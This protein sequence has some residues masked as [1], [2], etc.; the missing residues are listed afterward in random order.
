MRLNR[1]KSNIIQNC[2]EKTLDM[3]SIDLIGKLPRCESFSYILSIVDGASKVVMLYAIRRATTKEIM[4]K[5]EEHFKHYEI[6]K[7]PF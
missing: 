7:N 6:A 1:I 5:L 4:K 3:I 2:I